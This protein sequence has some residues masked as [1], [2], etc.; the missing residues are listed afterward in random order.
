MSL[1][2]GPGE[3][4]TGYVVNPG[5]QLFIDGGIAVGTASKAVVA[6]ADV[7]VAGNAVFTQP[8]YA[9]AIA[10]IRADAAQGM[11]GA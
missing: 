9:K 4:I 5:N 7:L 11:G 1:T 8:D 3:T 10:A 6:G 2:L